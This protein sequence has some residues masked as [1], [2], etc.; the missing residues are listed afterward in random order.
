MACCECKF[1]EKFKKLVK[2]IKLLMF[3]Y[4]LASLI[5][6]Y[7]L[8]MIKNSLCNWTRLKM[9]RISL[10]I[11]ILM[12]IIFLIIIGLFTFYK[13]KKKENKNEK[14]DFKSKHWILFFFIKHSHL[15]VVF[16]HF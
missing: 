16:L 6:G 1:C 2:I 11:A 7:S 14:K 4:L 3:V 13:E 9:I 5:F 12:S 15:K 8:F 10:S